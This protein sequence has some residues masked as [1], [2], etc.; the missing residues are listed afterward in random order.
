[1][2]AKYAGS[3]ESHSIATPTIE[4]YRNGKLWNILTDHHC[5]GLQSVIS[6][7]LARRTWALP[8]TVKTT[9]EIEA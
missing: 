4:D 1:M 5:D 8:R 9:L 7:V 2:R 3:F 6:R